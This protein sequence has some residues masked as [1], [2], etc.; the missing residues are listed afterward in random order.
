MK[1]FKNS[2]FILLIFF[3]IIPIF[4]SCKKQVVPSVETS[5]VNS[6][7]GTTAVSGGTITNEGSG[8]VLERGIYWSKGTSPT[9]ADNSTSDG[10]GAGTFISNMSDLEPATTYYVKA[11]ASNEAGMAY[12]MTMSF[13]TLGQP[14]LAT[15]QMAT[16]VT[17]TSATLNGVVNANDLTTTISFEYGI[18]STYGNN[19]TISQSPVNG[20]TNVDINAE[21]SGL[22]V[23]TT[24]HYRIKAVNSLGTTY[25]NDISF[26]TL[27]QAPT[28]I[29]QPA[30]HPT[31][32]TATLN[33]SVNPNWLSTTVTFEY[34]TSNSYGQTIDAGQNPITGSSMT[35]V[36]ANISGL[37][38]G[39]IYHYRVKATNSLGTTYGD[40]LMFTTLTN[41]QVSDIDGN[42]YY[43][44]Q[45]GSQTWMKY[46]LEATRLNDGT[47]IKLASDNTDWALNEPACCYYLNDNK[48]GMLYNWYA[49]ETGKLCPIGFR[50]PSED[51]WNQLEA[52]LGPE[53]IRGGKLKE[54]GLTHWKYPNLHATDEYGWT[55]IPTY[56]RYYNG[57]WGVD[58][59][60]TFQAANYWTSTIEPVDDLPI[61]KRLQYDN[62]AILWYRH[63]RTMGF[64]VRCIKEK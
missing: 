15:T 23:G 44:F 21:I 35:D 36:N 30:T 34:G 57:E 12:G 8:T 31:G 40:D 43:I 61:Y 9:I 60:S 28:A 37:T 25:S 32:L 19:V 5:P 24:Y 52:F 45:I 56:F 63:G 62:G 7:T 4:H 49:V 55:A 42:I 22:D 1:Y 10:A 11:Y 46:D 18:T 2:F 59:F 29:T 38:M 54:K 50:V 58:D 41:N 26:T 27:G 48:N 17:T 16:D 6:I 13:K 64:A 20:N 33:A 39:T 47:E 3:G 53:D 14:P 51:D